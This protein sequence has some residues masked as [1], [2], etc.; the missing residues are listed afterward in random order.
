MKT[1]PGDNG[2]TFPLSLSHDDDDVDV[3]VVV[4]ADDFLPLLSEGNHTHSADPW[5]A[6]AP[7]PI[8]RTLH[9]GDLLLDP[10][11]KDIFYI[12][13]TGA[14]PACLFFPPQKAVVIQWTANWPTARSLVY[15]TCLGQKS[16]FLKKREEAEYWNFLLVHKGHLVQVFSTV[17]PIY[18][19]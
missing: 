5:L 1:A 8:R 13:M 9:E 2:Q 6:A 4:V 7:L 14:S 11:A 12:M 15:S 18:W 3:V 17:L 16:F 10:R 19:L